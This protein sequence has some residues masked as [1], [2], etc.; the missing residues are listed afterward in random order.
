MTL[1]ALVS[2]KKDKNEEEEEEDNNEPTSAFFFQATIDGTVITFEDGVN[3]YGNG[4]NDASGGSLG[5][6]YQVV[7]NSITMVPLS[8]K[9]YGMF[10]LMK[11][12]DTSNTWE[13]PS[14]T[15]VEA[16]F[17]VKSYTY[18][19]RDD[20]ATPVNGAVVEYLDAS[21]TLWSSDRGS[22]GQSGSTFEITE[23]TAN[24]DGYSHKISKAKFSC[25]LYDD[26]GNTLSLTNGVSKG[27]TVLY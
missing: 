8:S 24:S 17:S 26:N 2:C 5:G 16:M 15:E 7:Q 10:G 6:D 13:E 21:G 11:T 9:A 4:A 3:G 22:A 14:G 20:M 27:R 19:V 18:G 12:F 1:I 23:H 25:T